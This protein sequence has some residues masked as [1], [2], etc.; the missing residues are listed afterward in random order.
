MLVIGSL[1][2][3]L[4]LFTLS[5]PITITFKVLSIFTLL[6]IIFII[7]NKLISLVGIGILFITLNTSVL[8]L[9]ENKDYSYLEVIKPS[10]VVKNDNSITLI[11]NNIVITSTDITVYT[12]KNTDICKL[13]KWNYLGAR[14]KDVYIPCI[15]LGK[16]NYVDLTKKWH[17][18]R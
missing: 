17:S 5:L 3:A 2:I 8:L 14:Q 1:F 15:N 7:P 16:Y 10:T 12:S 6:G 18:K 4:S 13:Y 9:A 11:N